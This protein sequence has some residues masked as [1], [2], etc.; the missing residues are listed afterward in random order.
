[1]N[2][3]VG[4]SAAL[5]LGLAL[6]AR[7]AGAAETPQADLSLENEINHYLEQASAPADDPH[8]I[9]WKWSSGLKGSSADG[10]FTIKIGGRVMV[11]WFWIEGGEDGPIGD[12][13][14]GVFFRRVRFHM[15]GEIFKNALYKVEFDFANGEDAAFRSVYVGLKNVP[16]LGKLLIGHFKEPFSLEELTSSKYITLMERSMPTN[17]FA[18]SYHTGFAMY[19]TALEGDRM[20][21]GLGLFRETDDVGGSQRQDGGYNFTARVT[22]V[23][24]END[25]D[26]MLLHAGVSFSFRSPDGDS[27]RYRARGG[28]GTGDRIVDTGSITGVDEVMLLAFELAFVWQSLSVQGEFFYTDV[29]ATSAGDPAFSGWYVLVSYFLTGE[30]RPYKKSSGT[31]DRVK[32]KKN[33]HDG[34]DGWGAWELAFR[35]DSI[36]LNDGSVTGGEA[37]TY[38]F[39]VNWYW[40]P[41][42]RVMI[43]Y[44]YADHDTDGNVS[45]IEMRFQADF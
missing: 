22:G 20:Q 38:V 18:P 7:M 45:I 23:V 10:N 24:L 34:G 39:G 40:N 6:M 8:T 29:S 28:N 35:I 9:W 37:M 43:N 36:D 26:G 13:T 5:V 32:P 16:V 41:N 1:M 25:E 11:D 30:S 44:A 31:F 17:A 19:R 33:F 42:M 2:R 4:R 12:T 3:I 15:E 27:V 14:D 21:Y